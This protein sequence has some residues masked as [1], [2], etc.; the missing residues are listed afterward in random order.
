MLEAPDKRVWYMF[1]P[2]LVVGLI[3]LL[4]PPDSPLSRTV[5]PLLYVLC[6]ALGLGLGVLG[7][8][9]GH[10]LLRP[11]ITAS[12]QPIRFWL[13]VGVGCFVFAAI[14]VWN[15]VKVANGAG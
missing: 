5:Q 11:S 7:M 9:E 13:D 15:L 6:I 3:F 8:R 1:I 10:S 14:G 4:T 12:E 2:V